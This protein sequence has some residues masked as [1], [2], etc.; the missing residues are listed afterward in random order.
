MDTPRPAL[1]SIEPEPQGASE[2]AAEIEQTLRGLRRVG[3]RATGLGLA[4]LCAVLALAAPGQA[5]AADAPTQENTPQA[6]V[7]LDQGCQLTEG[8]PRLKQVTLGPDCVLTLRTEQ[9]G[10]QVLKQVQLDVAHQAEGCAVS[11]DGSRVTVGPKCEI[12]QEDGEVSMRWDEPAWMA[13][14]IYGGIAG[15]TGLLFISLSG[16][17][18]NAPRG[19]SF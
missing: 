11:V 16:L 17:V 5:Q 3:G 4:T 2:R 7:N 9:D 10:V 6:V 19:L 18:A 12:K 13:P 14:V 15:L 8:N 1:E